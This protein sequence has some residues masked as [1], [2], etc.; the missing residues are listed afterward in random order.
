MRVIRSHAASIYVKILY[1]MWV[2]FPAGLRARGEDVSTFLSVTRPLCIF[3]K[4]SKLFVCKL[5]PNAS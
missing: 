3:L 4:G 5:F 1:M 2:E